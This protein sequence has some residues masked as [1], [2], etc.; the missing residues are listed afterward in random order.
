M[1][2]PK[3]YVCRSQH[4][5][6]QVYTENVTEYFDLHG[7]GYQVVELRPSGTRDELTECLH[8]GSTAVLGYNSQLDH[9]WIADRSFIDA[10]AERGV[11]VVQWIL[12][13]PSSRWHEFY[14]ST[15]R[16]SRFLFHSSY[17]ERY[18]RRYCL[19]QSRTAVVCGVGPNR[20]SRVPDLSRRRFAERPISCLIA[21]NLERIGGPPDAIQ[22]RISALDPPLAASVREAIRTAQ[23]D[24]IQ[25]LE[26]H[27]DAALSSHKDEIPI[28]SFHWLF[29]IVEDSV[30]T[31]RR[32]QV[33]SI[34]RD[35]RVLIQSDE[36]ARPF[37]EA[38]TAVFEANIGM[39]ATVSRM[40]LA[41][42][43]LSV[44]HLNDMV[45]DRTLNGL[46]AGCLNIVE[47]S[48]VHRALFTHR[49]NALLF[50]YDDDSLRECFDIVCRQ[51]DRAFAIA[52]AG[53][54]LR[55]D[56]RLRFG[57]FD[58]ILKLARA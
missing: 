50:R 13:H 36:A 17:S 20:R 51:P 32:Q 46:N 24:L 56:P 6:D 39:K 31:L 54:E 18:F 37:A 52:N 33:F 12:D 34:A 25:P 3:V 57:G 14:V 49:E 21:C 41:R 9:S 27:L 5:N 10:A 19:P 44:S 2:L 4:E 48:A 58:N 53:M 11:P 1:R 42:A 35:Y 30:Q 45:H 40:P 43:V 55:D 47:D 38:G 29:Q 7:V 16:N 8:D 28:E 22:A 26:V 23:H 15:A